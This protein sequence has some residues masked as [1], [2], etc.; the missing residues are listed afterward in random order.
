MSAEFAILEGVDL[1]NRRVYLHGDIDERR[2]GQ[3]MRAVLALASKSEDPIEVFVC[4]YGG[5]LNESFG[6]HDVMR[7]VK[8]PIITTAIGKC[9]SAAPLL[10]ACGEPGERWAT[11][12]TQFMLHPATL[13]MSEATAESVGCVA[14][15]TK[16]Q[17]LQYAGLLGRYTRKSAIFWRNLFTNHRDNYFM[18]E[19]AREWGLIDNIWYEKD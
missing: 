17:M 6:L 1:A 13:D 2:I 9:M 4:S 18:A 7:S 8:A 16:Q 15:L 10:V 19:Q 3:A 14:E 5:E 12:H 11:P